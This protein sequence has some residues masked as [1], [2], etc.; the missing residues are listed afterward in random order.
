M[1]KK[2]ERQ[3]A[4]LLTPSKIL[5]THHILNLLVVTKSETGTQFETAAFDNHAHY[6]LNRSG[7]SKE[8]LE[9][10]SRLIETNLDDFIND[11]VKILAK[12]KSGVSKEVFQ[13]RFTERHLIDCFKSIAKSVIKLYHKYEHQPGR[14]LIKQTSI[15]SLIPVLKFTVF[16]NDNNLLKLD[17]VIVLDNQEYPITD[18]VIYDF[19]LY[20]DNIYTVLSVK[21]LTTLRW[22]ADRQ[23]KEG[24][25]QKIFIE[26]ILTTV[27]KN[28]TVD[29]GNLMTIESVD[30]EPQGC[31]LF[32]EISEQ[33]LMLTPQWKYEEVII[34]GEFKEIEEVN[35]GGEILSI[36]RNENLEVE[37][38]EKIRALHPNFKNQNRG[39]FY[40]TFDDAKKKHW[41][42]KIFQSLLSEDVEIKGIDMLKHFRYSP[43]PAD[44]T[45]VLKKTDD[46]RL[47]FEMNVK[48]GDESVPLK[49]MQKVVAQSQFAVILKDHS[50]GV[51]DDTWRE[52]YEHIVRHARIDGGLLS[53]SKW[54]MVADQHEAIRSAFKPIISQEWRQKWQL[55][56]QEDSTL[57]PLPKLL[58]A[59]LRPYQQKGFEWMKLLAE[60]G[61]G[62]CLA[63]DM[64][65]G[66]TLQ[67]ITFLAS[68][69]EQ[70]KDAKFIIVCPLSLVENW[71]SEFEKFA[72]QLTTFLF[73]D[74][75]RSADA[76]FDSSAR[77]LITG[78]HTLRTDD[79]FLKAMLWDA[80][81]IDE[82]H[83]IKNPSAKIA[84][85]VYQLRAKSRVIL[86]GTPI[87]NN[88]MDLHGQFEFI[89][90]DFLGTREFFKKEFVLQIERYKRN[91]KLKELQAMTQP[92][93]LR[94]TK[95]QVATDLPPKVESMM[96]CDM[97]EDQR[98]L[99][100][101]VKSQIRD[102]IFL[103]VKNEGLSKN[104]L[105]ILQGIIKL[106][107]VCCSS[108]LLKDSD[109]EI[110]ESIKLDLLTEKLSTS[111]KG[112]KVL[113]FSQ[114]KSMLKLIKQRLDTMEVRS[115]ILDGDTPVSERGDVV[116][117][118][119]Q[120]ENFE[121]FLLS[122]KVGN[123]GLNLT[124]AE[125]VF[126]VDPWWNTAIQ[127]QAIDRTH[128]IG[129]DK[130][131]FAY[132]MICRNSIEEK[133]MNI[134]NRKKNL[135]DELILEDE[136]FVKNLT[137][138]DL[139]YLFE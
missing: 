99:Y 1:S 117:R 62:V 46:N 88:T 71:K 96:W 9:S 80:A 67:T 89:L 84:Q 19:L 113:V 138:E 95:Q 15:S 107:Q 37:F 133:I 118:F 100:E 41:F 4:V 114:F 79:D 122:L 59:T 20:R 86:S 90:P 27:E 23:P 128:R 18:F 28:Y 14:F 97:G 60:I 106:R 64:G 29:R 8:A 119:Q 98:T 33:F 13:K 50:I 75:A 58:N 104:K 10:Y 131:V 3:Y 103:Q 124:A 134:Q 139:Q 68:I 2:V 7:Y 34:D 83:N 42:L 130:T 82:S 87:L 94:R 12:Q 132:Q 43:H 129:Q 126:L 115:E 6:L 45:L 81:V 101:T 72:P 17:V 135:A 91:D 55:W 48:F 54:L 102:S 77:V 136:G 52:K 26:E 35:F 105:N 30:C 5:Y 116:N 56:Q 44:T 11:Q 63:D 24:L 70:K 76:F 36:K 92:F 137:I 39:Y 61:A 120:D 47:Y 108:E 21:D 40:L 121:V 74:K 32:S 66:K 53:V 73:H 125:Y 16:K 31:I 109:S 65:L 78:Y 38:V 25:E 69:A 22:L 110:A 57:Y 85:A 127:Q 123:A 112:K 111:L 93:I 51:F 49:E